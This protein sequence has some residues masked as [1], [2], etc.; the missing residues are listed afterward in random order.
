MNQ[1]KR[2]NSQF[3]TSVKKM[4]HIVSSSLRKKI[5]HLQYYI[6]FG[7]QFSFVAADDLKQKQNLENN[8]AL[9]VY[10]L[11]KRSNN[12]LPSR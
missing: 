5:Q 4:A 10:S 12:I 11:S 7:L 6:I 1:Q 9:L 3:Y 2:K 8:K